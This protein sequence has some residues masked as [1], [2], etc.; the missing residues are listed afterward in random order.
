VRRRLIE[1]KG[2]QHLLEAMNLAREARRGRPLTLVGT[3]TAERERRNQA[4]RLG[5]T[6][7]VH[8]AGYVPRE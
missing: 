8:F 2:Q 5:L 4:A 6:D 7:R 1:R 3:A